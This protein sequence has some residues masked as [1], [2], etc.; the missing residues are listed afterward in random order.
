MTLVHVGEARKIIIGEKK[1]LVLR[2]PAIE[3]TDRSFCVGLKTIC[4]LV[5]EWDLFVVYV[6]INFPFSS[7]SQFKFSGVNIF[8]DQR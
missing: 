2:N 5:T 1:K 7:D 8:L 4:E 6:D 3:C